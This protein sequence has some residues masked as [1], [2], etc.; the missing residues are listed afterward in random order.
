MDG[1]VTVN[2]TI[3]NNLKIVFQKTLVELARK[4][5]SLL[6]NIPAVFT[7]PFDG[8]TMGITRAGV[9]NLKEAN[10]RNA[11][12][13]YEDYLFDNRWVT[14]ER[15]ANS[16]IFDNA[17]IKDSIADPTSALYT[18]IGDALNDLK[19]RVI[20]K[21]AIAPVVV[22]GMS[23]ND[24]RRIIQAEDDGVKT[25]DAT[26]IYNFNTI[27]QVKKNFGNNYVTKGITIIQTVNEE[28]KL[29]EEEKL[30]NNYYSNSLDNQFREG[31]M[32]KT[33]GCYFISN[34]AG[35]DNGTGGVGKKYNTVLKEIGGTRL[36]LA[37]AE[38]A[39]QFGMVDI[40]VRIERLQDYVASTG[41]SVVARAH[42]L[43]LQGEKVQ[44]IK[45]TI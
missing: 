26:S 11:R 14:K 25:V 45:T 8:R 2:G 5:E 12:V 44:I 1:T 30:I 22:G 6:A 35:S 7:S 41:I 37:L 23:P 31:S 9:V 39:I 16:W 17:D 18:A 40:E 33:L 42:A 28:A 4:K 29:L 32:L 34:F 24:P 3:E 27:K 20:V 36:C 15:W 13:Q 38:K 10:E 19:D 43:R 21:A